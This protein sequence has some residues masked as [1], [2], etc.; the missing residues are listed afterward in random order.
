MKNSSSELILY[1][2]SS[3][4]AKSEADQESPQLSFIDG[5]SVPQ[6]YQ[7]PILGTIIMRRNAGQLKDITYKRSKS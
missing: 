5:E 3:I 4:S 7:D 1:S 6:I 2:D